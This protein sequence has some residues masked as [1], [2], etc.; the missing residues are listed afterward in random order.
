MDMEELMVVIWILR[1]YR[2]VSSFNI[3]WF[4]HNLAH[5]KKWS[6]LGKNFITDVS[7]DKKISTKFWKLST[8]DLPWRRSAL[9]ECFYVR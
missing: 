2:N 6:K 5:E 3:A 8:P 1:F 9:F 4:F 7:S